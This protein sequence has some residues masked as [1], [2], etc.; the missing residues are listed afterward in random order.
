MLLLPPEPML[1]VPTAEEPAWVGLDAVPEF[2]MLAVALF[3]LVLALVF[4]LVVLLF[5]ITAF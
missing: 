2:G 3:V 4:A 5:G 1:L